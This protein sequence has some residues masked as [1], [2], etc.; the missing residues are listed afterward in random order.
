[1]NRE[2]TQPDLLAKLS[3]VSFGS[4]GLVSEALL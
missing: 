1:M 4:S 2:A 3:I